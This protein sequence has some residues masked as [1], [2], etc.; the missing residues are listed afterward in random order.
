VSAS[1]RMDRGS[2]QLL[3]RQDGAIGW[4]VFNNPAR[5]NAVSMAMCRALLDV[6]RAF[7]ADSGVRLVIVSG[8]GERAFSAG[9]DI[10]EFDVKR[11]TAAAVAEYDGLAEEASRALELMPK[12]KI[13][14][15]RG[16]CI[17]GGLDLA[18]RCDIRIASDDARFA[19]P[20]ARL[21][22]GYAG[23]DVARLLDIVGP[24]YAK[25]IFYSGRQFS[26]AE[27]L[28]MRLVNRMVPARDLERT[29]CDEANTI[30]RNAPYSIAALK[31][32]TTMGTTA[33]GA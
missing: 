23:S 22:L 26:A 33:R 31:R 25:E 13:A 28:A 14:M 5:H 9:A 24:A 17:G 10:S 21:G 19:I 32:S 2:A 20:A 27:A 6:A 15:I 3:A 11:A 12:P 7:S 29:V 8:A 30:I 1:G 18:L 16:Y 4:I